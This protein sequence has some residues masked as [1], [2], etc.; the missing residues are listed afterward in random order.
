MTEK[1]LV[2]I[3]LYVTLNDQKINYAMIFQSNYNVIF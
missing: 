3:F 1:K 2:I